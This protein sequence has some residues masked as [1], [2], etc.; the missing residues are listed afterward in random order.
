MFFLKQVLPISTED[1]FHRL[2]RATTAFYLVFPTLFFAYGWLKWP[3]N[4]ITVLLIMFFLVYTTKDIYITVKYLW[5]NQREYIYTRKTIGWVIATTLTIITWLSFSGIGG[6]GY[7]NDDYRAKNALFNDLINQSFPLTATFSGVTTKIVYYYNYYLPSVAMGKIFGW[8]IANF[9]IF[10]WSLVGIMLAFAWFLTISQVSLR[11]KTYKLFPLALIFCL[12]GGLDFIGAYIFKDLSFSWSRHIEFWVEYYQYSSNTTL[13]YWAPQHA[14][15]AWLLTGM[16]VTSI[17]KT[18][19]LKYIA[20]SIAASILWSPFAIIG[21]FPYLIV[22]LFSYILSSQKRFFIFNSVSNTFN[23]IALWTGGL[24]LLY[25]ESNSFSFPIT[26]MWKVI[27]NKRHFVATLLK[28]WFVEFGLL[29][30]FV[31]TYLLIHF[32]VYMSKNKK[33]SVSLWQNWLEAL[34]KNFNIGSRQ[35]GVFILSLA[36]LIA[37]PFFK[38]GIFNDLVMRGSISALFVFWAII[39]KIILDTNIR[40]YS[41]LRLDIG[42]FFILVTLIIGFLTGYSEIVRSVENYK[43]G[44]P[45]SASVS[46]LGNEDRLELVNQRAGKDNTFFYRYI[47]K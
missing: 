30:F 2:L 15:P 19:N 41:Q 44:P 22:L 10:L 8:K 37:L 38:M 1:V 33:D 4:F 17:Y 45:S 12:A 23:I 7:Q 6:I 20:M 16:V 39:S 13:V 24:Y 42:Y 9:S 29:T 5:E 25:I 31:A 18:Q 34:N 11:K 26:V 40:P 21:I 43:F 35:F 32:F 3:F 36:I 47:G 27:E 46:S 14:I 28:F